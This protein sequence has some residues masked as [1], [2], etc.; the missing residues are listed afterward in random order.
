MSLLGDIGGTLG[1]GIGGGL[2]A[3]YWDKLNS[4]GYNPPPRAPQKPLLASDVKLADPLKAPLG[5][6]NAGGQ[7]SLAD[8]LGTLDTGARTSAKASGRVMGGYTGQALG[9]ANTAASRGIEDRVGGVLGGASLQDTQ[10]ERE[11]QANMALANELGGLMSPTMLQEILGGL[12]GAAQT[13]GQF[14][15][16]YNALGKGSGAKNIPRVSIAPPPDNPD[17]FIWR[18]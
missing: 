17:S 18:G 15:S 9:R 11:F 1:G 13:G 6:I 7:K 8:A 4:N 2:L 5:Q 16:L 10:N 12:G 14:A 3:H